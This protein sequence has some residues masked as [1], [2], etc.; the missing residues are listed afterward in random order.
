MTAS[1]L[2]ERANVSWACGIPYEDFPG[3][4]GNKGDP[5]WPFPISPTS[6]CYTSDDLQ[7]YDDLLK[8]LSRRIL[9]ISF[10]NNELAWTQATLVVGSGGLGIRSAVQLAPSAFIA[11]AAAS[12]DLAQQILPHRFHHLLRF[13]LDKA[14]LRW[15]SIFEQQG[16][17]PQLMHTQKSWDALSSLNI[18]NSLIKNAPDDLSRARISAASAKETGAWLR[19][20]PISNLGL[21]M[22][23]ETVRIAAGLRLG[24]PLCRSH[25]CHHCGTEVDQ[26]ATHGL[27][28]RYSKGRH[29]RHAAINSIVHRSLTAA[30]IPS[31][32][33]PTGLSRT[34]GKRP[35]GVS[36]ISWQSGK[37]LV[38][39]ATCPDT[40]ARSHRAEAVKGAGLVA[41][42]AENH[43]K[44][45]ILPS[46][47]V[48]LFPTGSY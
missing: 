38:W 4:P 14:I 17:L 32:L 11:S 36:L 19:A 29:A 46:L 18:L 3:L 40:F 47:L 5:V 12:L 26:F 27:S 10:Q 13:N 30:K 25:S 41:A 28:C 45:K 9:N 31:R 16:P 15:E 7:L 1:A 2:W 22:D 37:I 34:D 44:I 35:D 6:P 33:E 23:D 24:T 20:L 48:T 39:D 42:K 21:R 43:E 8:S